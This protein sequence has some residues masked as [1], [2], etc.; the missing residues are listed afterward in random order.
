[1]SCELVQNVQFDLPDLFKMKLLDSKLTGLLLIGAGLLAAAPAFANPF[2]FSVSSTAVS[3]G[4]DE[5]GTATFTIN[6]NT[7]TVVLENT[8]L[9]GQV[10]GISSTLAGVTF[11]TSGGAPGTFTLE[12]GTTIG[13]IVDCTAGLATCAT[14]AGNGNL[15]SSPY[16]WTI[17]GTELSA[18]NGS[19][20]PAAIVNSFVTGDTDGIRN[21]PHND[22]LL[23]P[24]TFTLDFGGTAPTAITSA[25]F[26]FGTDERDHHTGT[27]TTTVSGVPEPSSLLLLGGIVALVAS[28]FKKSVIA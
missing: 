12:N 5:N 22:Y 15:G 23:G 27:L 19:F 24:V 21:G 1:M 3:D 10:G 11:T 9:A 16:G 8:G 28:R 17:N 14:P 6:A 4:R 26:Q 13:G 20:K 25:V 7:I 2:V 18:G